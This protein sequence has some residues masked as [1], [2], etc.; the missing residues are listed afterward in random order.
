[1]ID[2]NQSEN[3]SGSKVFNNIFAF[4]DVCVTPANEHKTIVSIHQYKKIV[5][6]NVVK[7]VKGIQDASEYQQIPQTFTEITNIPLGTKMGLLIIN[8]QILMNAGAVKSK[9]DIEAEYMKV[10]RN[11]LKALK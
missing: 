2:S 9:Y 1:M 7:Q 4:G 5:A 8:D 11:D 3:G 6:N 10:L